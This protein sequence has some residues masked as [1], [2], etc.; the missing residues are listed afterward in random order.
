MRIRLIG[1]PAGDP[2]GMFLMD[3]PTPFPALSVAVALA[4]TDDTTNQNAYGLGTISLAAYEIGVL[5]IVQTATTANG[6]SSFTGTYTGTWTLVAER[7]VSGIRVQC[8]RSFNTTAVSGT[9][10][11]NFA[12]GDTTTGCEAGAAKVLNVR[13][14]GTNGADA[15]KQSNTASVSA[16]TT[17]TV[18]VPNALRDG[19]VMLYCL[20][21]TANEPAA[22]GTFTELGDVDMA[23]PNQGFIFA[24][25]TAQSDAP[26]WASSVASRWI[27]VE[28]QKP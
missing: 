11:A 13:R 21:H 2:T 18:S 24:W 19:S 20:N 23:T 28:V 17:A 3:G 14:S 12:A 16:N 15:I 27:A 26:T 6:V 5:F 10:I 8:Y 25:G 4:A 7:A 1:N 22:P 9:V